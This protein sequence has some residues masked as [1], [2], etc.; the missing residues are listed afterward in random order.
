M[1]QP[2][3]VRFAPSPTGYLHVGGARTAFYNYLF[4][5]RNNGKF[6]IRVEDTDQERSKTEYLQTL[7]VELKWLGIEWDEGPGEDGVS[8]VGPHGPY[9]QSKRLDIYHEKANELLTAGLAYYCFLTDEEIETQ[10]TAAKAQGKVHRVVSPYRD[11]STEKA[12]EKKEKESLNPTMRF[13]VPLETKDYFL[14]DIVRGEVR[15]PSDMVGDFVIVRSSGMP[16]YNFVCAIDDALMEISHVFRAEEHLSNTLRQMMI[17]EGLKLPVPKF[18]HLSIMLGE[19]KQKLSKRHGA[20]SVT[21]F[22]EQG[23]LPEALTN[24]ITLMGWSS[25][26]GEE[27]LST[28]TLIKEFDE[29]RFNSAAA[30]FDSTKLKWMNAQYLRKLSPEKLWEN[31]QPFLKKQGLEFTPSE[32]WIQKAMP[33]FSTSME[34]LEDA[35]PLL[36]PFARFDIDESANEILSWE[37]TPGLLGEWKSFLENKTGDF[38]EENDFDDFMNLAKGKGYKGKKLFMPLRV[39]FIGKAHGAEM[40]ALAP[41]ME[42][43]ELIRRADIVKAKSAN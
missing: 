14:N 40:K 27:V 42:R 38:L 33:V 30:V 20:T 28:E 1:S 34:T 3:R 25:P 13:K 9:Y 16:V 36:E 15:F 11:W 4:A 39:S 19:D 31:I 10:K 24:F 32:S 37:E 6:I 21:Q 5:K 2:V 35:V 29:N 18:G 23:Y 43:S 12:L 17:L 26:S 7:L 8:N 41:L 22:K